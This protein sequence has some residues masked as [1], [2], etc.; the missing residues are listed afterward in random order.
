MTKSINLNHRILCTYNHEVTALNVTETSKFQNFPVH[1]HTDEWS[2]T[3]AVSCGY[4][5]QFEV[6]NL[7]KFCE[8]VMVSGL[9]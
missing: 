2:V 1:Y 8:Q 9:L 6:W 7:K 4:F 3:A 5:M